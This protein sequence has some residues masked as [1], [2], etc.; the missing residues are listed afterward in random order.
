MT[1]KSFP[2]C[3]VLWHTLYQKLIYI[4]PSPNSPISYLVFSIPVCS[5]VLQE[6]ETAQEV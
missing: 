5:V 3:H 1:F 2:N 4:P 6:P